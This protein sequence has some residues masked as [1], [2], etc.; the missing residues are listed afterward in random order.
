MFKKNYSFGHA[1]LKVFCFG[2]TI[3]FLYLKN[4]ESEVV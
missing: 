2:P 3:L 4:V 1:N